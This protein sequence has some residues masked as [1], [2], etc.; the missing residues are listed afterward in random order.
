MII[1]VK[2]LEFEVPVGYYTHELPLRQKVTVDFE[3]KVRVPNGIRFKR[4]EDTVTYEP[5]VAKTIEIVRNR[6]FALLE[7]IAETL[8][9]EFKNI[10]SQLGKESMV[11]SVMVRVSKRPLLGAGVPEDVVAEV[12]MEENFAAGRKK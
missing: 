6:Q 11:E 7:Q 10:I 2:G 5:F 3:I 4:L 12:E 9:N 8:I 1:R